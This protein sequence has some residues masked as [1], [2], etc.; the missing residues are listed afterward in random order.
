MNAK[1]HTHLLPSN[2]IPVPYGA[3]VVAE[4]VQFTMFSRNGTRVWLM[5]FDSPDDAT[6]TEEFELT[7]EKNRI[8]DVWHLHVDDA[9]EGQYYL[10]RMEGQTPRDVANFF[11]PDQW[12][13]DPYA[14]AISGSPRWGDARGM[15]PGKPPKNGPLFPKGV[16]VR[17]MFD[18]SED[19]TP[20]T[21]LS[22]SII[23]EAHVRGFTAHP[24]SGV[25]HPG[26]YRGLIEKIPYLRDLGITAVEL[27]PIQE[28]NEMEYFL[29]N[30]NRRDLRNYWGYSSLA[31]FAPN[32]RYAQATTHGQQVHEF[33]EM[34]VALHKAGIE[35]ILDVVFNHTAEG[36]ERGPY[37]SYRGIDNKTY[38]L[39]TPD[40]YYFNFSG[41]GN[42]LNCNNPIVRNMILDCLRYWAAD[43]H[44]DGFRFDLASILGRDQ[45]GA[46]MHSPP[47]LES[48]AF[49]PILG[50]CKLIAEAWDAGGLY[51]V[52]S[53]PAWGRWAEWNGKYRDDLRRFLKG[54]LGMVGAMAQ[55]LQ[56]SP[57]LYSWEGRGACASINFITAHDGFTL[58]DMVSYNGKHNDAN[59]ENNSDGSND[60]YSWN[61]G[62]EGETKDPEINRL[63]M[64][65]MKNAIAMLLVS[66]GTPMI[67]A[68]D[69]MANT[70]WGNNNA[71]CQD[72]EISWLDWRLLEKN[73]E[74]FSFFRKMIAFRKAHPV[75]RNRS[76]FQNKDYMGSGIADITWHGQKAWYAD[77]SP[78]SRR[79]A[80]LLCGRHAK[81]GTVE[82][83]GIY[84]ALNMYWETAVF[85]LPELPHDMT[86]HVSA[87]T[88]AKSPQ[89]IWEP[90][91]EVRLKDQSSFVV[92]P[93]SVVI[94]LGKTFK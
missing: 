88:D 1:A 71:Y 63:R 79:I 34:V 9:R 62:V 89:D 13:L 30:G 76:H 83:N 26:T 19:H 37:I 48:L 75:L 5:L 53:F 28:F 15:Q 23:Y 56:G 51:Q 80:F 3:H 72:N 11:D 47:L 81:G 58:N 61:C 39:L 77:W 86:W 55:R 36:N 12:L 94:L 16:I 43:Y 59:G 32:G 70:Q 87:N 27:L 78:E 4:G 73:R 90:G 29:E 65:Q 2:P 42:T 92:G 25:K 24:S 57:D 69:E 20:R 33:Q 85:Q 38:Y 45:H 22:K 64:K 50:K 74:L 44:V 18:W 52:G 10:Y 68:G 67:L 46:P 49:D 8:G 82:D 54:D 35:V 7:A 14:L 93:R 66:Q 41:C 21:P 17:N 40:G 91:K 6:P 31:F 84:V 60:N